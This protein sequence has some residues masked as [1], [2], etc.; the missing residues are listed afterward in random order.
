MNTK[1]PKNVLKEVEKYLAEEKALIN[2]RLGQ[3]VE[4]DPY[5]DPDHANDNADIGV[6]V[7]EEIAH[8]Q[9]EANRSQL[10][11]RLSEI[12]EV[13]KRVKEDGYGFCKVCSKMIDTDRLSSNPLATM[14]ID[15]AKKQEKKG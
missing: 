10:Q 11:K 13:E 1:Y 5:K 12:E 8:Q 3:I 14:C 6:D 7:R 9:S 2:K 15:C 4:S